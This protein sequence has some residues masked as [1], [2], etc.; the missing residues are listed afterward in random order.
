MIWYVLRFPYHFLPACLQPPGL[1]VAAINEWQSKA[2]WFLTNCHLCPSH[3]QS[4]IRCWYWVEHMGGGSCSFVM[5]AFSLHFQSWLIM[6]RPQR[7]LFKNGRK[8]HLPPK[9]DFHQ[10]SSSNKG[11]LPPEVIFQWRSFST[12]G[13]L[14]PKVVFIIC[15]V[16]LLQYICGLCRAN[17][18]YA[19]STKP[20][21]KKCLNLATN[22][23]T[24]FQHY[25]DLCQAGSGRENKM[26]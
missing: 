10:R 15:L 1:V 21:F 12:K 11:R 26:I 20:L 13:R 25:D 8:G 9:V 17:P 3:S 6:G 23:Q 14:P 4:G 7:G 5:S 16:F 18:L 19:L 2:C 24:R 22:K